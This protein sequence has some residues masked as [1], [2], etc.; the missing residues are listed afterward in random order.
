[1]D[2]LVAS[3]PHLHCLEK[4][5]LTIAG[6]EAMCDSLDAML[7]NMKSLPLSDFTFSCLH[8][9]QTVPQS[10]HIAYMLRDLLCDAESGFTRQESA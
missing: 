1:M 9:Y 6:S 10:A 8:G 3:L 4:V 7:K 5:N 2:T